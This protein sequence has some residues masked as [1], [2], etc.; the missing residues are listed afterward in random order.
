M[1]SDLFRALEPGLQRIL[2]KRPGV[3]DPMRTSDWRRQLGTLGGSH[4]FIELTNFAAGSVIGLLSA[5]EGGAL[6]VMIHSGSCG[7]GN[8][9]AAHVIAAAKESCAGAP[10][11][12]PALAWLEEGAALFDDHLE[13]VR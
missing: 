9:L 2:A 7:A 6:W 4:H 8:V 5:D 10:L 13:A 11:P 12:D 1:R 3:L